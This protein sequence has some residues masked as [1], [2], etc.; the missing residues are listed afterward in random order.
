MINSVYIKIMY[1]QP[2]VISVTKVYYFI[3]N[4]Y[5]NC[6]LRN[7]VIKTYKDSLKSI[8]HSRKVHF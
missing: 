4:D 6:R 1:F 8:I 3:Y 5:I 7:N 2:F